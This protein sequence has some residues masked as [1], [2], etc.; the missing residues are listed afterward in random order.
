MVLLVVLMV[1]FY[2]R[3]PKWERYYLGFTGWR[4]SHV[5]LMMGYRMR[6]EQWKGCKRTEWR[7][8]SKYNFKHPKALAISKMRINPL[9]KGCYQ[10]WKP[11]QIWYEIL[12]ETAGKW[13]RLSSWWSSRDSIIHAFCFVLLMHARRSF[14]HLPTKWFHQK[15]LRE[16]PPHILIIKSTCLFFEF[17]FC[18]TCAIYFSKVENFYMFGWE[19]CLNLSFPR[20]YYGQY[21]FRRTPPWRSDYL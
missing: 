16:P 20:S 2:L 4:Y 1:C 8:S 19:Y 13:L 18:Y 9:M 17:V 14:W 11:F 3:T 7:K 10:C 21:I 5:F 12:F 15:A 6:C